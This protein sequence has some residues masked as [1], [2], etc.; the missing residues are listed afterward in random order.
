MAFSLQSNALFQENQWPRFQKTL[1]VSVFQDV[2]GKT[3]PQKNEFEK[4][5]KQGISEKKI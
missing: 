2:L 1:H 4:P 5:T 3:S